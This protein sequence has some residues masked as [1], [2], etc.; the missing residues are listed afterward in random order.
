MGCDI[1]TTVRA[2]EAFG[3][4]CQDTGL[5]FAGAAH[6]FACMTP[7]FERG[8]EKQKLTYLP[9]LC[10]GTLIAANAISEITHGSDTSGLKT[11]AVKHEEHYILNG[12]KC[13]VTNASVADLFVVYATTNKEMG[14]FGQTTFLLPADTK[15]LTITPAYQKTGLHSAQLNHIYF[16]DCLVHESQ[17]LGGPGQGSRI[18]AKSM[19]YERCCLFAIFV[20]TMERELESCI[21]YANS[22]HQG[23]QSISRY[24]AVSH[25]IAGMKQRLETS[26]LLLYKAAWDIT[27]GVDASASVALSKLVISESAVENGLDS[28]RIHGAL[29]YIKTN[30]IDNNLLDSIGS[31]L[32][33]GTSDIQREIICRGLGLK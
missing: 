22:R 1:L 9:D 7:I 33:S 12:D 30:K 27:Q 26:R 32:F 24:Q 6:T 28:I 8:N 14:Y 17:V 19:Q 2:M 18:F 13:Y 21:A 3:K 11:T 5:L 16:T 29:G 25:R 15:G 20:G 31:L 10:R 23:G 4:G